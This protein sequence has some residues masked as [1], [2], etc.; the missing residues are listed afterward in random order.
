MRIAICDDS[1][2]YIKIMRSQLDEIKRDR[3][4]FIYDVFCDGAELVRMYDQKKADYD[5]IF[6]DIEMAG[7]NGIEVANLIRKV[8]KYVIIVFI[9]NYTKYMQKSFECA[10]FRF[11]VKPVGLDEL[12]NVIEEANKK[13]SEERTTLRFT[14]NRV[15][16]R[17]FCDNIIYF[18]CRSH[19]VFIYTINGVH[20]VC[21]SISTLYEKLDPTIFVRVHKSFIVNLNYIRLIREN[22]LMLYHSSEAIPISRSYKKSVILEFANFKERKYII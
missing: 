19:L 10:P 5:V 12:K 21:Y 2:E 16:V 7:I 17:L 9:T 8:D 3:K 18:E 4:G 15:K 1:L 13:L 22:E 11:L 6:L 14:E 20:K